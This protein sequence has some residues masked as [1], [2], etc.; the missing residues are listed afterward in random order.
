MTKAVSPLEV[1]LYAPCGSPVTTAARHVSACARERQPMLDIVGRVAK[2]EGTEFGVHQD[3]LP[4]LPQP[5][6]GEQ[7]LQLRLPD[8]DD[9]QKFLL[10]GL[11]VREQPDLLEDPERQVL[12]L[13]DDEDDVAPLLDPLQQGAVDLRNQ[14]MMALGD[15][16]FAELGSGWRGASRISVIWV[17]RIS[18]VS[19]RAGSSSLR[20]PPAERGLAA[21]DLPDEQDEPFFFLNAIFEML[22]GLLVGRA[23]VEKLRVRSDVERHLRET[24]ETLIHDAGRFRERGGEK[25]MRQMLPARQAD[26]LRSGQDYQ[27]CDCAGGIRRP[28]SVDQSRKT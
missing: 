3:P 14:I 27:L 20:K 18:A 7:L 25:S 26:N 28:S 8:E 2:R 16:G 9:L 22:Q 21:A 24:V 23:Q 17:L 19:K 6:L 12:G 15:R 13:V 5:V 4:Q 1:I 10:V 11:E